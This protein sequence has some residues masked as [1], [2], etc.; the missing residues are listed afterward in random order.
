MTSSEWDVLEKLEQRERDLAAALEWLEEE[1]ATLLRDAAAGKLNR[2]AH[3]EFARMAELAERRASE[4]ASEL[5]RLIA[6]YA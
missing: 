1:K 4:I 3:E 6:G 5:E 2:E